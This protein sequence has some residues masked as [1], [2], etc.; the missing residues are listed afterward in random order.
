[1]D[2]LNRIFL[3]ELVFEPNID[4][5]QIGVTVEAG[6]VT[7][8]GVVNVFYKKGLT[9]TVSKRVIGVKAIAEDIKVKYGDDL[10]RA[11][12]EIVNKIEIVPEGEGS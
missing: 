2:R 7:L 10:R 5:T 9:N 12:K 4:E 11:D 6:I 1:M 3:D 8:S